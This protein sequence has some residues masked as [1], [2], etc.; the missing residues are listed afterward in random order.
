MNLDFFQFEPII[1]MKFQLLIVPFVKISNETTTNN[2]MNSWY[3]VYFVIDNN[4]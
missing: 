4:V 1:G 2:E 3:I